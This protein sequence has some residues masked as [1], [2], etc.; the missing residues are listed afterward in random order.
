MK[1]YVAGKW[2]DKIFVKNVQKCL[3]E[4]GHEITHDWTTQAGVED[5]ICAEK[6]IDGVVQADIVVALMMDPNYAYRGTFTEI[7]CALGLKKRIIILCPD[8]VSAARTNCFFHH[9]SI[10]HV[11]T[12]SELYGVLAPTA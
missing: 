3:T 5:W 11:S 12:M 7:G 1:I 6:D 9:K 10:A 8:K 4:R 2:D